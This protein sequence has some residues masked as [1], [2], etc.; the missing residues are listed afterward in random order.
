MYYYFQEYLLPI[1]VSVMFIMLNIFKNIKNLSRFGN[2]LD[3]KLNEED[4]FIITNNCCKCYNLTLV[5]IR[6]VEL[7]AIF[8]KLNVIDFEK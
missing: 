7:N 5:T 8:V 6:Y 2:E 4:I 1:I 3:E